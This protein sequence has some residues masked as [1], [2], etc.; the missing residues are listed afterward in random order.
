MFAYLRM[1]TNTI[2]HGIINWKELIFNTKIWSGSIQSPGSRYLRLSRFDGLTLIAT[3]MRIPQNGTVASHLIRIHFLYQ[4]RSGLIISFPSFVRKRHM[5]IYP[6][7][8]IWNFRLKRRIERELTKKSIIF[9]AIRSKIN[10]CWKRYEWSLY[11]LLSHNQ[12][13]SIIVT[14]FYYNEHDI[15]YESRYIRSNCNGFWRQHCIGK[16]IF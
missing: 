7:L 1:K 10:Y 8:V 15:Q 3:T 6:A 9:N 11:L 12:I 14:P 5:I 13:I 2:L 4:F 16:A